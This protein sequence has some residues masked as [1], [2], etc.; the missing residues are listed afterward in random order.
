MT[1]SPESELPALPELRFDLA[2]NDVHMLHPA[3]S[4]YAEIASDLATQM[5][6]LTCKRP[7]VSEESEVIPDSGSVIVL[8]NI[9]E[10]TVVRRLYLE[11]YDFTDLAFPGEGG[12][13]TSLF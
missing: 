10:S 9:M 2:R 5:E 6:S 12:D 4:A 7:D 11:A 8:G 13:L 1:T 3:T